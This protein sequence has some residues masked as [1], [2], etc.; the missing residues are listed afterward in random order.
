MSLEPGSTI[1]LFTDGL[2]EE[3]GESIEVGLERLRRALIDCRHDPE[4]LCD[5]LLLA[6][7]REDGTDDDVT[8]LAVG[9]VAVAPEPLRLVLPADFAALAGMRRRLGRWLEE[10]GASE[11]ERYAILVACNEACGNSIE[12]GCGVGEGSLEL[13]AARR[14]DG[15][16][17]VVRDQGGWREPRESERGRGLMLMRGLMASVEL[18]AGPD[19][20]S[21]ELRH[22]IASLAEQRTPVA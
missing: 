1:V 16:A 5:A 7:G 11:D 10:L 15:V 12:H 14:G 13:E 22:S 6:L 3:R 9:T 2:V 20:T 18:E 4:A 17:I 19:G 21:V 8:V